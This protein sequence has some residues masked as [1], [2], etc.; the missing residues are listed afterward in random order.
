MSLVTRRARFQDAHLAL[1]KTTLASK[2]KTIDKLSEVKDK[3][4][5]PRELSYRLN[6][7]MRRQIEAVLR[8]D[9]LDVDLKDELGQLVARED[10][11]KQLLDYDSL[12]EMH[13]LLQRLDPSYSH[14]FY[15][16]LD[17]CK[18]IAPKG[19]E[20]PFRSP[21][22]LCRFHRSAATLCPRVENIH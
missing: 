13:K 4:L 6:N 17:E 22:R 2:M 16:L 7:R 5:D 8:Q 3:L 12:S 20:V 19:K 1:K 14:F 18:A 11:N 10:E 9:G 21:S 15:Q